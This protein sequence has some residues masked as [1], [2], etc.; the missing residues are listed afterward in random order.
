MKIINNIEPQKKFDVI[1]LLNFLA[2]ELKISDEVELM[3]FYNPKLLNALSTKDIEYNAILQNP[4]PHHYTLMLRDN[5]TS[6][7]LI[8]C[9][10]MIHLK[11]YESGLL[12]Q[13]SDF[14]T[15]T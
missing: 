10:E 8:L 12:K 7:N 5:L 3:L 4:I 11:Q 13:S 2:S 1:E 15:M 14:K 6:L 9:H